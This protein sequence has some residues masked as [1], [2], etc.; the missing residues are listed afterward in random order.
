MQIIIR[1]E[2]QKDE[3]MVFELI[4]KA[5]ATVVHSDKKEQFLVERLRKKTTFIPEL[6]LVATVNA[7][8][9]GHIL[10]TRIRIENREKSWDALALAPVSV[11]PEWQGKGIGGQLIKKSHSIALAMGFDKIILIGHAAYYPRFGYQLLHEFGIKLP[12]EVPLENAMICA[13]TKHALA[14]VKGQV[15]YPN[16]FFE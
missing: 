12:F 1:Q 8:L 3:P 5:F 13:L 4:E 16:E 11:L 2:E 14:G 10:L 6:S 9:V 15:Q 7:Q